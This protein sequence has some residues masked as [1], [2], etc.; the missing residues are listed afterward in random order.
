MKLRTSTKSHDTDFPPWS[1]QSLCNP[2]L[3]P[4][5]L[6]VQPLGFQERPIE[7]DIPTK[8]NSGVLSDHLQI[9]QVA[10]IVCILFTGALFA[11]SCLYIVGSSSANALT[12]HLRIR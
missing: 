8:P 1:Y 9:Y 10:I 6:A 12:L 11:S 2:A 3:N 4:D 5:T 7:L